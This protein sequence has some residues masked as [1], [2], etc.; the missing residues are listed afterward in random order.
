[1]KNNTQNL[2]QQALEEAEQ[3]ILEYQQKHQISNKQT[4]ENI[5]QNK[6]DQELIHTPV[7]L[8]TKTEIHDKQTI[9]TI[10]ETAV[11]LKLQKL[12]KT[13][14][15]T[16]N[17]AIEEPYTQQAIQETQKLDTETPKIG[18]ELEVPAQKGFLTKDQFQQL[19]K[20]QNNLQLLIQEPNPGTAEIKTTPTK[21]IKSAVN[22]IQKT[23]QT[24]DQHTEAQIPDR[25]V[26]M[27]NMDITKQTLDKNQHTYPG[28]H[29]H[30][31]TPQDMTQKQKVKV[32]ENM[33][34]YSPI[35]S[36]LTAD[37]KNMDEHGYLSLRQAD[38]NRATPSTGGTITVRDDQPTIE[39]RMFDV[40]T[41]TQELEAIT[42]ATTGL[43]Q[44]ITSEVEYLNSMD[45]DWY[46]EKGDTWVKITELQGREY[47][48]ILEKGY[49]EERAENI[50]PYEKFKTLVKHGLNEIEGYDTQEYLDKIDEVYQRKKEI[51]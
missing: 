45:I 33:L 20:E 41:D 9:Q 18:L 35:L 44:I 49:S 14:E 30:L 27:Y 19:E 3:Q 31:E 22:T 29:I 28:I 48:K 37:Q 8:Q 36:F 2:Y 46:Q 42:A 38:L 40:T 11:N 50:F 12:E 43:H 34:T 16:I 17:E 10:T 7:R 51:N 4:I 21:G 23:L 25:S 39:Y 13:L 24:V 15:E 32:A 26:P 1:M 6:P 47:Q 5:K